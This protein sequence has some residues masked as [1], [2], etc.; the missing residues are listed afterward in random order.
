MPI[1]SA[2]ERIYG[3]AVEAQQARYSAALETYAGIYGHGPTRVFRAPGRVNLIGEHTDYNHGFVLPVPLD[4][5]VLL[6]A[7]PRPDAT[8]RLHNIE[9]SFAPRTFTASPTIPSAPQGDWSNYVRGAAQM[10]ARQVGSPMR[11]MD[12]LVDA[13]PPCGIPRGA[14][15][16]SSSALTVVAALALAHVNDWQP[17]L[18]SFAQTCSEAEW[19]VGTRG[20]IMDQFIALLA[21]PGHALFLD[22][23]P[24]TFPRSHHKRGDSPQYT[25]AHVPLP[26]DHRFLVT[27]TG[28]RH[29][30][31]RGEYNL[32]VA[33]CRAGV[34]CLRSRYPGITHL[35][36]VQGV[37]WAELA[38]LLPEVLTVAEAR[39]H[40]HHAGLDDVPLSTE[41]ARLRVRAC[42][43]HVHSENDRV[44]ATVAALEAG[45]IATVGHLLNQ[46]HASARDDYD[47]SCPELEMLVE[48]AR[49]VAGTAGAR[50]TGAGWGGCIVALVHQKAV[51]DFEAQVSRH[52]QEQ[53]GRKPTIFACCAGGGAGLVFTM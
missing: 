49:S 28:V 14:G 1:L 46:A 40:F 4:R 51:S 12:A 22:C 5:D 20:G 52:Y 48:A 41:D 18:V 30:N 29:T 37:A 15:L 45:D 27:D 50:L 53:T 8:V 47:I 31:V 26:L 35:R 13:A 32:R 6:L 23:R 16:S 10:V 24:Q 17:D 42:C 7:H 33:A 43:R 38:P 39:A 21:H 2:L 44:Q 36:D 19:Y 34:A 11:G 3:E 25:F 9:P